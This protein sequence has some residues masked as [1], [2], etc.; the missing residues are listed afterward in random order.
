MRFFE[1][2]AH[3]LVGERRDVPARDE[4]VGQQACAPARVSL[5]RCTTG[6]R[7]QVR[8]A[9]PSE[10]GRVHPLRGARIERQ[11]EPFLHDEQAEAAH[12][13]NSW[14]SPASSAR[15]DASYRWRL[16]SMTRSWRLPR[17]AQRERRRR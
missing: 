10:L 16:A 4:A 9:R 13:A 7:D 3:G 2:V 11:V 8:R 12:C 15:R 17:G 14:D 1:R 5:R 6:Q